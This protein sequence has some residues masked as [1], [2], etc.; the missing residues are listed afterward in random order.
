MNENTAAPLTVADNEILAGHVIAAIKAIREHLGCPLQEA[1]LAFHDRHEV[2]RLEQ[3]DAFA[4]APD[5]Y[6]TGFYS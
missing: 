5:E 1:L 3:P 6:G 2:L 4:L